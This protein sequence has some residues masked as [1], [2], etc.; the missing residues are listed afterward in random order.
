MKRPTDRISVISRFLPLPSG[1]L[2]C[3]EADLFNTVNLER[4]RRAGII[5]HWRRNRSDPVPADLDRDRPL[6]KAD[7]HDKA[8]IFISLHY[9]AFQTGKRAVFYAYYGPDGE[10]WPWFR[11]QPRCNDT[12]DSINLNLGD[13][14][15][16][17][18]RAHDT[19][20]AWSS[21]NREVAIGGVKAAKEVSGK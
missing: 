17:L 16:S 7:R 10:K 14:Y 1:C 5:E 11:R 4:E 2:G 18:A 21:Q 9:K 3:H 8:I 20:D 13:W 15:R 6:E 12:F 19:D